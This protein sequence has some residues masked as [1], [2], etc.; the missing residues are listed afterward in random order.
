M[1]ESR[2]AGVQQWEWEEGIGWAGVKGAGN[3]GP[4]ASGSASDA[5][6]DGSEGDQGEAGVMPGEPGWPWPA[7]A[8][9]Q[10]GLQWLCPTEQARAQRLQ[11][12]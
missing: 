12:R 6:S 9:R 3:A 4:V 2:F 11:R 5:D 7:S 8:V 1:P 10:R